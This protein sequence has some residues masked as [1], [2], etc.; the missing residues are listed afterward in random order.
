MKKRKIIFSMRYEPY[1]L[2]LEEMAQENEV[3]VFEGSQGVYQKSLDGITTK[4]VIYS[5]F[6]LSF[7]F[8]V[9]GKRQTTFPVYI[10]RCPQFLVKET[11]TIIIAVEFFHWHFF[12]I[13]WHKRRY[14]QTNIILFSEAKNYPK[15]PFTKL[16]FIFFLKILF[17]VHKHIQAVI[18]PTLEGK[19]FFSNHIPDLEVKVLPAPIDLSKFHQLP[20][21]KW[22]PDNTLRIIMNARYVPYKRHVDLLAAVRTLIDAGKKCE[23]TLISRDTDGKCDIENIV[24][25]YTLQ[26]VVTFL[27]SCNSALLPRLYHEYD[28]LVLPSDGEAIGMVVPEAMACG[29]PTIT[30]DTVGANVYVEEGKTGFV[31]KAKTPEELSVSLS[32][33][34]DREMLAS[35]GKNAQLHIQQYTAQS[36]HS[37]MRELLRP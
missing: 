7:I 17:L 19:L 22:L 20:D 32:R 8:N 11:P 28:V 25:E 31:V 21:K 33:C 4:T 3:M 14:P 36:V 10:H 29:L 15:N 23:V 13:L 34:F 18:V 27:P 12:Q 37:K 35:M 16:F 26:D 24:A 30:S 1:D 6:G 2:L 9:L 5:T